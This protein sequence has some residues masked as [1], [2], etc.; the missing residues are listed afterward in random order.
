MDRRKKVFNPPEA[1]TRKIL[2]AAAEKNAAEVLSKMRIADVLTIE[3]SGLE[4]DLYSYA[5]MAHFDFVVVDSEHLPLFAVEFDGPHHDSDPRARANDLRKNMICERLGLP[6]ARVRD[7]HVFRKARGIDY[8]SWLTEM[9]FSQKVLGEAQEQGIIP[10]D[11]PVDPM[12]IM[13]HSN[14]PGEFP[15]FISAQA[16]SHLRRFYKQKILGT[17]IPSVLTSFDSNGAAGCLAVVNRL[18]GQFLLERA[19]I[20]LQGFGL[21]VSDICEEIAIANLAAQVQA[22]K[23]SVLPGI[24]ATVLRKEL[25]DFFRLYPRIG[26]MGGGQFNLGFNVSLEQKDGK[27]VLRIG[28]L[29][30]QPEVI[31]P[32]T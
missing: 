14:V 7:E 21:I 27:G 8:L 4:K 1:A 20:Y 25:L 29:F 26:T 3:R 11:E 10:F 5:L 32:I 15:L 12:M 30:G 2:T 28:A 13:R 6:L 16:R 19:T 17:P 22:H 18:D 9:Y 23:S 24:S 31:I